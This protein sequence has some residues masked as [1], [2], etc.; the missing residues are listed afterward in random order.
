MPEI[1][2]IYKGGNFEQKVIFIGNTTISSPKM[3]Y[4]EIG[5]NLAFSE[6]NLLNTNNSD[7]VYK[8]T[9]SDRD[10]ILNI[11]LRVL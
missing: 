7:Y 5:S 9:L 6:V 10:L 8:A 4:R 3:Y 2:Q 1:T 11:T